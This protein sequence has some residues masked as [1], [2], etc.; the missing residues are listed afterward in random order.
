MF[1]HRRNETKKGRKSTWSRTCPILCTEQSTGP[2]AVL[3]CLWGAEM[4]PRRLK[5]FGPTGSNADAGHSAEC[6]AIG[7]LLGLKPD[8]VFFN[9][10]GEAIF[11]LFVL[12]PS[13]CHISS[14]IILVVLRTSPS[15]VK[16]SI[17]YLPPRFT[18]AF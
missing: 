13:V 12:I 17:R 4:E 18:R 10:P 11:G 3:I 6:C 9:P 1:R 14:S 15:P 16:I 2:S 7:M 5:V 8:V